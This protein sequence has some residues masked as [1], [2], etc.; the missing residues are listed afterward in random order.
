MEYA[1]KNAIDRFLG[2]LLSKVEIRTV[3]KYTECLKSS[4]IS[5]LSFL[6]KR[7]I[8]SVVNIKIEDILNYKEE[9][10]L[11]LS[12]NSVR[13]YITALK[14]FYAYAYRSGWVIYNFSDCVTVP[15][16]SESKLNNEVIPPEVIKKVLGG[17]W[18]INLFVQ[19]R[20]HLIVCLLLKHG[21]SP[22]EFLEIKEENIHL[23]DDTAYLDVFG[24]YGKSHRVLLDK[25]SFNALKSYLIERYHYIK[26]H[27]LKENFLFLSLCPK[28]G[29]NKLDISGIQAV[30]RRIKKDLKN[31]GCFYNL[32]QL[33]PQG[34]KRT[35]NNCKH[36][37]EEIKREDD[38]T[39]FIIQ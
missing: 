23:Y 7:N 27:K 22:I 24:K 35:V 33:N 19:S 5:F 28:N 15:Q 37:V 26:T 13:P 17:N 11:H 1:L 32:S 38:F 2:S 30:L 10:L 39:P 34:C 6:E 16:I 25:D 20:N 9:L 36:I 31:S 18:G 12:P 8:N 3:V 21:I 29:S 4:K 14:Q